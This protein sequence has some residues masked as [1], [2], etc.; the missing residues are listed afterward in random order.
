MRIPK[1]TQR[2]PTEK[3]QPR[4][5]LGDIVETTVTPVLKGVWSPAEILTATPRAARYLLK[6]AKELGRRY[7]GAAC[8][9]YAQGLGLHPQY[10]RTLTKAKST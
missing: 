10:H 6:I 9:E 4:P 1:Q 8:A 5:I 2:K 7:S 3:G